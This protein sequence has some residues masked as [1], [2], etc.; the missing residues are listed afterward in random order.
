MVVNDVVDH[1]EVLGAVIE[2]MSEEIAAGHNVGDD[3]E[4]VWVLVWVWVDS[5]GCTKFLQ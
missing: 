1:I 4:L 5:A 2:V 3:L